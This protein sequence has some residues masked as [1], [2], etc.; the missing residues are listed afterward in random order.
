ML[1]L[2][3]FPVDFVGYCIAHLQAM[4]DDN[5]KVYTIDFGELVP[6]YDKYGLFLDRKAKV[7]NILMDY[8]PC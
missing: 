3:S 4:M 8:A 7:A 6:L 1:I 5:N 2:E